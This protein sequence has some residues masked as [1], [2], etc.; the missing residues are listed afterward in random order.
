VPSK[1]GIDAAGAIHHAMV[2]GIERGKD[3]RGWR[4]CGAGAGV[5]ARV[6][7]KAL[8]AQ[9]AWGRL[10]FHCLQGIASAGREAGRGVG[11][12]EE[13]A[14]CGSPESLL[15]L[16]GEGAGRAHVFPRTKAGNIDP[17]GEWRR[18]TWPENRRD[19]RVC[20]D[21]NLKT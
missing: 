19:K 1:S 17:V 8:R 2:R 9:S 7:G 5:C 4:F 15:P 10:G 3:F 16:G 13:S 11:R 20:P 21:T 14:D 6:H 12:R 18:N